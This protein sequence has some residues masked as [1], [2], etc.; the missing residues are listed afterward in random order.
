VDNKNDSS[1]FLGRR[2]TLQ[3]L[4]AGLAVGGLVVIEACKD[5]APTAGGGGNAPSGAGNT[6][7]DC[8]KDIDEAS[9]TLRRT[10]Q[11]KAKSDTPDKKCSTCAQFTPEKYGACGGGC[12]LIT[13][14]VKPNGVC[15]SYAPI[16]AG[17]AP[18]KTPT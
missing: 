7:D 6:P 5:N 9:T 1:R 11:Y 2:R 12:K 18:A 17:A 10:L 16:A 15:L 13:G 8:S 4:T 3:L 14:P